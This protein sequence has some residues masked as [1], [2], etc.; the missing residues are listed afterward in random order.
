MPAG[1]NSHPPY[2]I[3]SG[4]RETVLARTA[5]IPSSGNSGHC[6]SLSEMLLRSLIRTLAVEESTKS[7]NSPCKSR[8]PNEEIP[9]H[10]PSLRRNQKRR[11]AIP[12]SSP[13]A[14]HRP[15]EPVYDDLPHEIRLR[16]DWQMIPKCGITDP[17][18]SLV[19]QSGA[20]PEQ[21]SRGDKRTAPL[22]AGPPGI[23]TYAFAP[24]VSP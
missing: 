18:A 16:P 2:S 9:R 8:S 7:G 6:R 10:K 20:L 23:A 19:R 13:L 15:A 22:G 14:I 1:I 5:Q 4:L 24:V 12:P 3:Q 17:S 21:K 11:A